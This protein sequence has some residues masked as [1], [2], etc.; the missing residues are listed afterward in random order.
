VNNW[1][2]NAPR[3]NLKPIR[4]TI[5]ETSQIIKAALEPL[6]AEYGRELASLL[7]P[8]NGRIDI[9]PAENRLPASFASTYPVPHSIFYTFNYEGYYLDLIK[10]GHE[11]GHAVQGDMMR[12]NRVPYLYARGPAYFSESFGIFNEMLIADYLYQNEKDAARRR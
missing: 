9:V 11:A 4:F 2:I 1:D 10:L 8:A 3:P 5:T 7:D 6:G 12:N